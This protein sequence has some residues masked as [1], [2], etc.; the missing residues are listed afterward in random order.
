VPGFVKVCEK[1]SPE[2]SGFEANSRGVLSL[3]T[4]CGMAAL[5][6]RT[7]DGYSLAEWHKDG[8]TYWAISDASPEYLKRF[9]E[10]IRR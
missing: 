10:A 9:V 3:M 4:R 7:E 2:S 1:L 6:T 5:E 8:M